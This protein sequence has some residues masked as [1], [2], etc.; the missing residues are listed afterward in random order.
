[1]LKQE[2]ERFGETLEHGMKIL[3]AALAAS[4]SKLDGETA[5]KLYD[6]YGF[7]LDLTADICRERNVELDEAGF[8]A[9]MERQKS[10]ARAAGKFKM[11]AASN[12]AATRPASSA[13]NPWRR[14]PR[15]WRCTWTAA[16][17]EAR[18][19]PGRHRGAGHH[20]VLRRIRRPGRRRRCLEAAN[21]L[22]AVADTQRSRPMCSVTTAT[23]QGQPE[24]RR[25]SRPRSMPTSVPHHAQPLGHPPDAQGPARSAGCARAQKG[26]LVDADKTRFDFS[27]NAPMTAEQIRRV[28]DIVNREVL[29]NAPPAPS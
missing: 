10:A 17:A 24:G 23:D 5:F 14:R 22:F 18:G 12:T 26:S 1:V 16:G 11:A 3:E 6:T 27:H 19:R 9:A 15:S 20:P 2:E 7:P 21:G 8:D 28:E 29:A 25:P 13:T 4:S